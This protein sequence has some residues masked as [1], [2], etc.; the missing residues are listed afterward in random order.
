MGFWKSKKEK[1]DEEEWDNIE[2]ATAEILKHN[3]KEVKKINKSR[4]KK[5][6]KSK[7]NRKT[8]KK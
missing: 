6:S 1:E 7:T 8:N 3:S 2:Q 4:K 5:K